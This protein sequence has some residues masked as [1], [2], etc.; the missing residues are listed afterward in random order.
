MARYMTPY[1]ARLDIGAIFAGLRA[2]DAKPSKKEGNPEVARPK[3]N[4][5]RSEPYLRLVAARACKNCGRERHSQAAHPP[6][7]GKAIKQDDRLAFPLCTV[8]AKRNQL[9]CHE[10]FDRY[11]LGD[12]AW[13]MKMAKLWGRETRAEI[14]AEG[15]WPAKLPKYEERKR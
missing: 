14:I 12:R 6:P 3:D 13:T 5:V 10:Q 1:Q 2:A 7:E 4:V 15:K 11:Q 8:G 9:G